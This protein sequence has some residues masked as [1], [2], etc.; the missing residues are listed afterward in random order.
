MRVRASSVLV[1]PEVVSVCRLCL[2]YLKQSLMLG[3][4]RTLSFFGEG[5]ISLYASGWLTVTAKLIYV[6]FVT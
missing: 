5:N 4:A 1:A 3:D 6:H 2:F